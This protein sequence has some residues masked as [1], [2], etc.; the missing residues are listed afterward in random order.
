MS[1]STPFLRRL[2]S[3]VPLK[4]KAVL[5]IGCGEGL[6][7]KELAHHCRRVVAI[8]PDR[9]ALRTALK[10]NGADNISYAH[11]RAERIA[12]PNASFDAVV[13]AKSFHHVPPKSMPRALDEAL[14]VTKPKGCLVFIE[15]GWAGSFYEAELQFGCDHD[16]I[17]TI[18]AYAYQLM[19]S[20][21]RMKEIAEWTE[22]LSYQYRSLQEFIDNEQPRRGTRP[23]W[24]RFL[25][26]HRQRLTAE[27]RIN[28]FRKRR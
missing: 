14:R 23:E 5:D 25:A 3:I 1:G 17:R 7:T 18:K 6:W 8:D 26:R 12:F 22:V 19:L 15:L 11:G 24:K 28:V 27:E 13:F 9:T 10:N 16:D 21:R 20:E 4:D 2:Q